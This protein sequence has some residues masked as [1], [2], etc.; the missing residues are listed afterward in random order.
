[1]KYKPV[2]VITA[3]LS[4]AL[5]SYIILEFIFKT[6]TI[7]ITYHLGGEEAIILYVALV[8]ICV[9]MVIYLRKNKLY[10]EKIFT[11]KPTSKFKSPWRIS[12]FLIMGFISFGFLA[13]LVAKENKILFENLMLVSGA[14]LLLSIVA[15]ICLRVFT[16]NR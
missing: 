4:A 11:G 8:L 6:A 16:T 10:I 3:A 13:Q 14:F 12:T 7:E 1:M 15:A 9:M 2:L 5:S